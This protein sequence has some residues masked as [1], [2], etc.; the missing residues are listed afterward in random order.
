MVN[1]LFDSDGEAIAFRRTENDKWLWDTDGNCIG[2]FPWGDGDAVTENGDYIGTVVENRLLRRTSWVYRG[3]AGY[4]G[5]A[6]YAGYPG[7][8]GYAGYFGYLSGYEDVPK[9]LL[10]T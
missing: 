4:P 6:G 3:Y 8:A 5:Y 2:W 10:T 7:Y 9:R 1:F